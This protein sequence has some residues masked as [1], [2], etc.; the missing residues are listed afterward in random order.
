MTSRDADHWHLPRALL[1]LAVVRAGSL[2]A[3]ARATGHAKSVLSDHLRQLE[4][5]LGAR[6]LERNSRRLQ[7]TEVGER[8]LPHVLQLERSWAEGTAEIRDAMAEPSGTLR[9]TAPQIF[10]SA[11]VTPV[12]AAFLARFPKVVVEVHFDDRMVDLVA[13]QIDVAIRAGRLADSEL[14]ATRL[15]A[16]PHVLVAAPDLA[17]RH[18]DVRHPAH[19]ARLPWV[20]H[21]HVTPDDELT[22]A[23]GEV[24]SLRVTP[25]IQVDSTT[26]MLGMIRAGAG[27]GMLPELLV[28]DDLR[29]GHLVRLLP[30]WS[31]APMSTY[32]VYPSR[33]HLP[34][35][36][37]R[38]VDALREHLRD[39]AG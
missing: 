15:G 16:S 35:K 29:A 38:F 25:R 1:F 10:E 5:A 33:A 26:A 24:A 17:A 28:R 36:V 9:V 12:L 13:R 7:L 27:A 30:G 19:L 2:S 14:V 37:A 11:V 4:A 32:A 22:S 23:D 34:P 3:A 8:F 18:P 21:A 31:G 6:L 20:R 39:A